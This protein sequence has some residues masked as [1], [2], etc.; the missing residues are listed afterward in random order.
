MSFVIWG[1]FTNTGQFLAAM[2]DSTFKFLHI[3]TSRLKNGQKLDQGVALS[4]QTAVRSLQEFGKGLLGD[5]ARRSDMSLFITTTTSYSGMRSHFEIMAIA[6]LLVA[7]I[8]A[9]AS[10]TAI[11][12]PATLSEWL[13]TLLPRI[14]SV[15]STV[16]GDC[17]L[18][19]RLVRCLAAV[20]LFYGQ[21]SSFSEINDVVNTWMI[22]CAA[23]SWIEEYDFLCAFAR[24]TYCYLYL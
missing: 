18:S 9:G 11:S 4:R 19:Q 20:V 1:C 15:S 17:D 3:G 24:I 12:S 10:A 2:L 16:D 13:S 6:A 22:D 14:G 21:R 7:S 5:V 23:N 8:S